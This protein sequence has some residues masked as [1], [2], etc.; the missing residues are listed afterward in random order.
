MR[1]KNPS[2]RAY[3]EDIDNF[4]DEEF[5]LYLQLSGDPLK[6]FR[7]MRELRIEPLESHNRGLLNDLK[8]LIGVVKK[9]KN[10][11]QGRTKKAETDSEDELLIIHEFLNTNR[12]KEQGWKAFENYCERQQKFD[13]KVPFKESKFY[14]LKKKAFPA[15]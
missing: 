10:R 2:G 11:G 1:A 6:A 5:N 15:K 14:E 7:T 13:F 3:L 8:Q 9:Y 4:L 12:L